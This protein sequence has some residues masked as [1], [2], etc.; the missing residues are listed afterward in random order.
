MATV[1]AQ[2]LIDALKGIG[3]THGSWRKG[4]DFTVR[5]DVTRKRTPSG[6]RYSQF[7]DAM[8]HIERTG[9]VCAEQNAQALA[10]QGFTVIVVKDETDNLVTVVV[11]TKSN[12]THSV[13]LLK[14]G[15]WSIV[16]KARAEVP[17]TA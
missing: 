8:A 1:Q 17:S 4:G 2:D 13:S 15:E 6:I 10:C 3:L 5:T 14:G 11:S 7:G 16:P 12:P 9:Q